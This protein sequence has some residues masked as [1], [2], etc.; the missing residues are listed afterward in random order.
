M[1]KELTGPQII[2]SFIKEGEAIEN[3]TQDQCP[4]IRQEDLIIYP[5]PKP[6]K[7]QVKI[8]GFTI[9]G[10]GVIHQRNTGS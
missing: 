10:F 8:W 4:Q 9:Q 5:K 2:Q 6:K 1:T 3:N 7:G